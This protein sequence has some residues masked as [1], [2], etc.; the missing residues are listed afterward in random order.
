MA[1]KEKK[2]KG[3]LRPLVENLREGLGGNLIAVVLFGSHARGAT[4]GARDWDI[5]VLARSLPASPMRRYPHLR[6]LCDEELEGGVSFLAKTQ[7]EFE[8]GFPSFYL[9][10]AL[11]GVIL[12]DSAGYM[13]TKLNRIREI[14]KEAGL[15][16][17]RIPGGF[18]WE[19]K[20]YPAGGEWEISWKGFELRK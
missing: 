7:R 10:L 20:K 5:F 3:A 14:I 8:S 4:H 11:D 1:T 6:K 16:R 18:F 13:R 9:D 17:E 12:F 19:W 15:R 2:L